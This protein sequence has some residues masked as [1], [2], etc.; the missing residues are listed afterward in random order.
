MP[1]RL[2]LLLV[3]FGLLI[4]ARAQSPAAAI[5]LPQPVIRYHFGDNPAW[6]AP[7][8]NDSNWPVATQSYWPV[9]PVSSSGF[10]WLRI[11]IPLPMASNT[12]LA[13]SLSEGNSWLT[14]EQVY[15]QGKLIDRLGHFP[16]RP[17]P[18]FNSA[19]RVLPIPAQLA[20]GHVATVAIRIWYTTISRDIAGTDHFNIRLGAV[21]LLLLDQRVHRLDSILRMVP[22]LS[23]SALMALIGIPL[24]II[25]RS[26]GRQELLWF[27]LLLI[28]FS[29]SVLPDFLY[30]VLSRPIPA[31]LYSMVQA[32]TNAATMLVTVEF[33]RTAFQ[34]RSRWLRGSLHLAWIIFNA[35]I[36]IS[37]LQVVSPW[38]GAVVAWS[39]PLGMAA[40]ACFN[41]ATFLIDFRYLIFGPNRAIALGMAL[42][43]LSSATSRLGFTLKFFN[44]SLFYLGFFLAGFGV[45]ALLI[46]SALAAWRHANRLRGE[47]AAAREVQQRLVPANLPTVPGL[48]LNATYLPATEVGG[49]F[50]QIFPL[51]GGASLLVIGDVSGKGLKAAMTGTI[52]L[53]ALRSLAQEILSPACILTRLNTQLAQSSDGGFITCLCAHISPNGTLTVANAGHLQPYRNREEIPLESGLPLGITEAEEYSETAVQLHPGDQL[54]FLSD[55]VIEARNPQGELYGFE[56][57]REI[58]TQTAQQ[59]AETAQSFGQEDDITVLTLRYAPA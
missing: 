19:S 3:L 58:S 32:L 9:P 42:I 8:F 34:L 31:W 28:T 37:N 38:Q 7:T 4:P 20:S 27:S 26:S 16:P 36:L 21:P 18:V 46:K 25:W 30:L 5:A 57:T 50:Y 35:A 40:L 55:G 54:T 49:D 1:P 33:L 56:R 23:L 59:I 29:F 2:C 51:P 48:I 52:A 43:P 47:I 22:L 53:G 41:L 12:P 6:A 24:L 17:A 10:V 39:I 45:S 11:K 15:F 14:S 13:L 44:I